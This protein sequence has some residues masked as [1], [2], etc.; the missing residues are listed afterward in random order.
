[1]ISFL[2]TLVPGVVSCLRSGFLA[3]GELARFG[4]SGHV[5]KKV[6]IKVRTSSGQQIGIREGVGNREGQASRFVLCS[7]LPPSTV[8]KKLSA[9][10]KDNR[11]GG[12][13][14]PV[15][16]ATNQTAPRKRCPDA[17]AVLVSPCAQKAQLLTVRRRRESH[18]GPVIAM[19]CE[20]ERK[21][22]P[23]PSLPLPW[24]PREKG[25][26]GPGRC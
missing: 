6:C 24:A 7:C 17:G 8:K 5:R 12:G 25:L 13:M 21:S 23:S 11:R 26:R 20:G 16:R 14:G 3:P 10:L 19:A 15:R 2:R 4:C 18:S 22:T 9:A 1:M